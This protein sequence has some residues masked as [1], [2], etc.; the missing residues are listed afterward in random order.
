MERAAVAMIA[1]R[2][3]RAG[4]ASLVL[5]SFV[6]ATAV[7]RDSWYTHQHAGGEHSH[8]HAWDGSQL[9]HSTASVR[10]FLGEPEHPHPHPD[11][12]AHEQPH[13]PPGPATPRSA[14]PHHGPQLAAAAGTAHSHTQPPFQIVA[15]TAATTVVFDLLRRPLAPSPA[16][17]PVAA[18]E[19][20][21]RAR[22]PPSSVLA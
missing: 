3:N 10:D 21:P 14:S 12:V 7:P 8:V 13:Q 9:G 17:R 19:A 16:A 2:V 5:L 22:G 6:A 18:A 11:G 4:L 15:R 20:A 1:R